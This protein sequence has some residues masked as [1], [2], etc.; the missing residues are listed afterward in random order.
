GAGDVNGDGIDD[1]LIGAPG[2]DP[3][4]IVVGQAYLIFGQ[5]I[6]AGFG[7][8]FDLSSIDGSNGI[9]FNGS[10]SGGADG[11]AVSIAGD[12]NGDGVG[13]LLIAAGG[14]DT[15][16]LVL[17]GIGSLALLDPD[18][19]GTV[20]LGDALGVGLP[21]FVT[22]DEASLDI[23]T[24]VLLANDFD[25]DFTDF[26]VFDSVAATSAE[27]ATIAVTDGRIT[28]DPSTISQNLAAGETLI[29]T[30]TYE[31]SDRFGSPPDSSF[32]L[33]TVSVLV[34]GGNDPVTGVDD[35]IGATDADTA[36][37]VL[38]STLLDN[39]TDPDGDT[40]EIIAIDTVSASGAVIGF[41]GTT[42]TYDP[43]GVF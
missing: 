41:D 17:G 32:D 4:G 28:Y 1:L 3:E 27:G 8:S 25:P 16:Q 40:L 7:A 29:D 21:S 2:A 20:D 12:V 36:I 5:E 19:D 33:A 23:Q 30:F 11:E 9:A 10:T 39:D 26:V 24:N 35:D 13:D 14:L 22:T 42:V 37:G 6:A 15:V 18:G 38:A 43:A 34:I 31:V